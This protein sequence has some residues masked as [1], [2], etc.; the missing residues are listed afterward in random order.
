[1]V[2]KRRETNG[3]QME[4][5]VWRRQVRTSIALIVY[6]TV[7]YLYHILPSDSYTSD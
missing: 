3:G 5:E 6:T 7:S 1:V 2:V 4:E